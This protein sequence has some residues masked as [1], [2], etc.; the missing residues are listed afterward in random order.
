MFEGWDSF[1]L[2]VGGASGGLIGLL[3]VVATL[4][5]GADRDSSL[6]GASLYMTPIV[7][8][9]ATVLTL[10]AFVMIPRLAHIHAAAILA[11]AAAG[12]LAHAA[13]IVVGIRGLS[14]A[15]H[16]SDVWYYGVAPGAIYLGLG[17]AAWALAFHIDWA[18]AATAAA[19]TALLLVA[20][21]N[22]WDLVTW[23]APAQRPPPL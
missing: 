20:I 8:H 19:L 4:N 18:P 3:F 1:Y 5:S 22:A 10:S 2:L 16:W 15:P 7:Y 12:G 11:L 6:R 23:L 14:S 13:R 9:L 17:A 21:R